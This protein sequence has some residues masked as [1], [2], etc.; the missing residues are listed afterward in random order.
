MDSVIEIQR[1]THEDIERFERALYTL[2]S[3]PQATHSHNLQNEH[4]ASQ[5]MDRLFSRIVTLNDLYHDEDARKKELDALS[6]Q[7]H[8]NDLSEFYERLDKIQE[9]HN[10]YPD[11]VPLAFDFEIAAFFDEP[12]DGDED[13]EEEDRMCNS[14][15]YLRSILIVRL[16]PIYLLA[17]A[18][19][20]SGEEA[21]GKYLDLYVNHTAYN[22]LKNI[23]KRPG[24]LQYLDLL[25]AAQSNPVHSELSKE[26]RFTKDFET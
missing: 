14:P 10:K 2:L 8:Q 3:R 18:L 25:L 5:I 21:Y 16:F 9:H 19:L 15:F 6:A 7:S 13:F 11:A 1:Q 17:I 4:K 26:T 22:N 23:G 12:L 20:F 24:Y